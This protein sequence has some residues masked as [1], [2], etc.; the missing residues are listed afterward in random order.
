VRAD[1]PDAAFAHEAS[2]ERLHER[3]QKRRAIPP[4]ERRERAL[5]WLREKVHKDRRPYDL[6]P[7]FYSETRIEALKVISCLWWSQEGLFSHGRLFRSFAHDGELLPVSLAVWDGGTSRLNDHR[8]WIRR[9][10][11]SG[12]AVLALD[13]SGVGGLRPRSIT[14]Q[15]PE[16]LYGM[17]H[18]FGT[19]LLWLDDDLVSL[20]TYD[21]L[22]ALDMIGQWP[23]L[24][25][26]DIRL[27]THG[28]HGLYG[29]LAAALDSRIGHIEAENG[30]ESFAAW[31]GSRHYDTHDIYSVILPGA[32]HH[33]DLP[34]LGLAS[35][36]GY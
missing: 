35:K 17:T 4:T 25:A 11:E 33:F 30:M 7:R 2:V 14:L 15:A 1:F 12:R 19:D 29:Q 28:R 26:K 20:R 16:E 6:N 18:K 5:Q 22:R 13:V 21:V 8:N 9:T 31:I 27:Y 10:C 36:Q 3:E 23:E 24:D 34:E 32:L